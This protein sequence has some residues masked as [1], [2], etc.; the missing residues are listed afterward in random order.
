YSSLMIAPLAGVKQVVYFSADAL[1][2]IGPEDGELLWRVPFKTNAKRHAATP[3][4][5]GDSVIVNSHTIG[6]I[7]TRITREGAG[8]KAASAWEDRD[9]KINVSTPVL[10]DHF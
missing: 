10:V 9:L 4:I 5:F 7:C 6:L 3:I 1:M 2:G 8:L